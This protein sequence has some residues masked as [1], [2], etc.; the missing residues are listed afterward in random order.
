MDDGARASEIEARANFFVWII[1]DHLPEENS[2]L[3]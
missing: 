1:G 2:H 3:L